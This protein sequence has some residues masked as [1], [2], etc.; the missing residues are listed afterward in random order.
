MLDVPILSI[1]YSL[2]PEFPFPRQLQEIL[3]VYAWILKN[4]T[5]AGTTAKKILFV[6]NVTSTNSCTCL[7]FLLL[8]GDSAGANLVLGAALWASEL[9]LRLPDG[10]FL[11]YV[12]LLVKFV[13]SPSRLLCLT[14]P[15]LPF[16]FMMRCLNGI[17]QVLLNLKNTILSFFCCFFLQLIREAKMNRLKRKMTRKREWIKTLLSNM[18]EVMI[19]LIK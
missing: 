8:I 5:T 11:A 12:P 10:L 18:V 1:D 7:I 14:D 17:V 4:S 16:G 6:G 9:K 19:L 3:Y 15:L 13:P 2:A